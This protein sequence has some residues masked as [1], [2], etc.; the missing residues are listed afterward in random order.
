MNS[1]EAKENESDISSDDEPVVKIPTRSKRGR[2]YKAN[3]D[4][5]FVY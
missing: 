1:S 4:D 3:Q 5:A 2:I